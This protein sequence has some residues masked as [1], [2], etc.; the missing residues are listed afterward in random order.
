MTAW[1]LRRILLAPLIL[2]AIATVTFA[3]LHAAPGGPFSRE[4]KLD[5]SVEAELK[6]QYGLDRSVPEQY[7]RYLGGLLAGDLG[8]SMRQPGVRVAEIVWPTFAVSA[9]I[10]LWGLLLALAAG[11]ALGITAARSAG[12]AVDRVLSAGALGLMAVPSFVAAPLLALTLA[13]ALGWLPVAGW[14]GFWSPA[15]LVLPVLALSL[16]YAARIAILARSGYLGAADADFVRTARAK[17]AGEGRIAWR[18]CLRPA[19]VPVAAYLGPAAAGV[20]TGSLVVEQVFQLPGLG[21]EFVTA[22]TN[23]DYSL[24]MGATLVFGAAMV[25]CTIIADLVVAALDPRVRLA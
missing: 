17:G 22:V 24:V 14:A 9:W 12:G 15:H 11:T 3:L 20:L 5:P 13:L 25:A 2:F 18:H 1:L 10:G 6:R 16:P 7:A 4:R 8:P 21:G 23:R 19:L